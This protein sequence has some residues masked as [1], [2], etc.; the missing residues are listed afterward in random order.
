MTGPSF[1]RSDGFGDGS[2]AA[3]QQNWA[4]GRLSFA[5]TSMNAH[6]IL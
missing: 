3:M 6:L 4:F 5:L 2:I 1:R